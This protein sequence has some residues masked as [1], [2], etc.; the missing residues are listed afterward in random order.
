MYVVSLT[1][2]S[3][4]SISLVRELSVSANSSSLFFFESYLARLVRF[5]LCLI[6]GVILAKLLLRTFFFVDDSK[7]FSVPGWV[8]S[9][10]NTSS[11]SFRMVYPGAVLAMDVLHPKICSSLFTVL[12]FAVSSSSLSLWL[13]FVLIK[14]G[15]FFPNLPVVF[16]GLPCTVYPV[17]AQYRRIWPPRIIEMSV[18]GSLLTTWSGCRNCRLLASPTIQPRQCNHTSALLP[19]GMLQVVWTLP[20]YVP[21]WPT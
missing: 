8:S 15:W 18:I 21:D 10:V 11:G 9:T 12:T 7:V 13:G 1:T 6:I 17:T 20:A 14:C 3:S 5:E 2:F 4:L 19:S 16:W